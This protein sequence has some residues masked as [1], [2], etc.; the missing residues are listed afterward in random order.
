MNRREFL[1]SAAAY[2]A[3]LAAQAD[4]DVEL[5]DGK[6]LKGWCVEEGPESAFYVLEGAIAGSESS[7]YPAWL[8]SERQYENFDFRCE[9]FV[10]GWIDGGVYL[11]APRHG[12]PASNGMLVNIFHQYDKVPKPN[13]MGAIFPLVAPSVVNVKSKGEWNSMRILM[14][15][16]RLKVWVNDEAVQDLDLAS[17]PELRHRFRRGYL[18]LSALGYPIRFRNL[19]IRERPARESWE[20]LYVTEA[21]FQKWFVSESNKGAPARFEALG[22]VIRAG[23]GGHLATRDKF[24]DFALSLF[25]RGPKEHNGGILVRSEG[26][27]LSG[28]RYYE[29]QLHNVEDAHFPTGSLYYYKRS[30]YPR[31]EDGK[32]FP[33]QIWLEGPRC[34]V[35]VNGDTV[36]EYDGLENRE[37]GH[38]ELQAHRPGTWLEF[39]EIRVLRL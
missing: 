39:K 12:R 22:G 17:H 6:S 10:S 30:I 35:R 26:K 33:M 3:A 19:R 7:Q 4:G 1:G 37:E 2:P 8:R 13:S 24:R 20:D 25:V 36:L 23:G 14:D 16:P 9:F 28:S 31:I 29:I 18:G 5:F 27:G 11:H 34:M 15:W 38:I 21:D 32:W